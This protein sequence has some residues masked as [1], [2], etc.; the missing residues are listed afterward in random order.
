ML[1]WSS[2]PIREGVVSEGLEIKLPFPGYPS[3]FRRERLLHYL[4]RAHIGHL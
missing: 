1:C 3:V 2:G 4:G